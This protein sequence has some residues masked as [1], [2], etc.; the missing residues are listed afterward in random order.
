MN[1]HYLAVPIVMD[2]VHNPIVLLQCQWSGA[3][4]SIIAESVVKSL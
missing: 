3:S 2:Y 4:H 1:Y